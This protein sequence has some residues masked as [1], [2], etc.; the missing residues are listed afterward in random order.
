MS[1]KEFFDSQEA[2]FRIHTENYHKQKERIMNETVQNTGTE[3]VTVVATPLT[4]EQVAAI[5]AARPDG[6]FVAEA[7]EVAVDE[8]TV[9]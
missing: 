8:P 9:H 6:T 5:L 2:E 1:L 7:D 4:D 3:A